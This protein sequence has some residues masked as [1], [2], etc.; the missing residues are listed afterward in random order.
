VK[1]RPWDS[2]HPHNLF[3]KSLE[4]RVSELEKQTHELV[5]FLK[6]RFPKAYESFL[7]EQYTPKPQPRKR[8]PKPQLSDEIL[9]IRRHKLIWFL[10]EYW[11]ELLK[12][13][14]RKSSETAIRTRL[15]MFSESRFGPHALHAKYLLDRLP[16][17]LNFIRSR[18]Y[19][20][21]PRQIANALA[22]V[23]E[24]AWPTSLK[25]C[26]AIPCENAIGP[27]A[28]RDYLRRNFPGVHAKLLNAKDADAVVRA[29]AATQ[30]VDREFLW[31]RDNPGDLLQVMSLG[32]VRE[33]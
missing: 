33:L 19:T 26:R 28:L 22:G 4:S 10:E 9:A 20:G 23:P 16:F 18:D 5:T 30:T 1:P 21:D 15:Q 29:M 13:L 6:L 14:T 11:P 7:A 2:T 27:R 17:L 3:G 32:I 31:M 25:R 24:N 12:M 8:G